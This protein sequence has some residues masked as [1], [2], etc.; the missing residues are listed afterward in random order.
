MSYKS[1]SGVGPYKNRCSHFVAV[2]WLTGINGNP[3]LSD[4]SFNLLRERRSSDADGWRYV[5][6]AIAIDA[7]CIRKEVSWDANRQQFSGYVDLGS[8]EDSSM[9]A[10]EALVIMA[11]GVSGTW[12]LPVAYFL[13]KSLSGVTQT[14]LIGHVLDRLVSVGVQPL[15]ITFDGHQTNLATAR[16][17]GCSFNPDNIISHFQYQ[18]VA[19]DICVFMDP[20][21][22]IKLV[23]NLFQHFGEIVIPGV[24]TAKWQHI[25]NLNE[26][27]KKEGL[28]FGNK[29][30]DSHIQWE[31][32][33]MK[34]ITIFI[35]DAGL[36]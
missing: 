28:R 15:S 14:Q 23:R 35:Y 12:K 22:M 20:V 1:N 18:G 5:A 4:E 19:H 29:L 31:N 16:N 8:G 25:I 10:T 2:S 7:M 33:K 17:L 3:G 26:L 11:V 21:H 27:Q 32:H 34:V 36:I 9:E 6:C 30:S 13:T 24:G